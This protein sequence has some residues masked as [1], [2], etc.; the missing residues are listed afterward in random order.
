VYEYRCSMGGEM[1]LPFDDQQ[2]IK[3][4]ALANDVDIP[5]IKAFNSDPKS[6][7]QKALIREMKEGDPSRFI[8]NNYQLLD[9]VQL[10]EFLG[11]PDQ[12]QTLNDFANNLDFEGKN[13]TEALEYFFHEFK[14]PGE[15]QKID[16]FVQAFGEAYTKQNPSCGLDADQVYVLSFSTLMLNTDLHNPEVKNKIQEDQFVKNNSNL[17]NDV[18]DIPEQTLR[19]I[20]NDIKN[21]EIDPSIANSKQYTTNAFKKG[22]AED[23]QSLIKQ[24]QSLSNEQQ[25]MSQQLA[26]TYIENNK[27]ISNMSNRSPKDPELRQATLE[28]Q[29]I[30][31]L[32]DPTSA[33]PQTMLA[34]SKTE[35]KAGLMHRFSQKRHNHRDLKSGSTA[36]QS[37]SDVTDFI[38][39]NPPSESKENCEKII[40][41]IET[42]KQEQGMTNA[43]KIGTLLDSVESM[44]EK[45]ASLDASSRTNL[46]NEFT[47]AQK[48]DEPR[49]NTDIRIGR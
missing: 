45:T 5:L 42:L 11:D 15:S 28:K 14:L 27:K 17:G 30:Q 16:R 4:L 20:Y 9:P 23:I 37:L 1:S 38:R 29:I 12:Q 34:T 3:S 26:S 33:D 13:F 25:S 39:D 35:Q 48:V 22:S 19:E 6:N 32:I 47:P 10:G 21:H 40:G 44:V 24:Q 49:R 2:K 31:M 7:E 46:R 18:A 36:L 8:R 41:M 43:S